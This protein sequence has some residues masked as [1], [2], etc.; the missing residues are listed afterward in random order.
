MGIAFFTAIN[1]ST[2]TANVTAFNFTDAT[3]LGHVADLSNFGGSTSTLGNA[4]VSSAIPK[5]RGKVFSVYYTTSTSINGT[6]VASIE[7]L[8]NMPNSTV[9]SDTVTNY[10]YVGIPVPGG[11]GPV[12]NTGT[13]VID[14]GGGGSGSG[15][16]VDGGS[17]GGNGSVG[18]DG[19]GVYDG[20]GI[21]AGGSGGSKVICTELYNQ[22]FLDQDIYLLDQEFGRWLAKNDP[23]AYWG[24]RAW[25]DILV[26]YMRGQGRPLLPQ[27]AFWLTQEQK[28]KLSQRIALGVAKILAKPFAYE[29]ARRVDNTNRP[30]R[31]S[32]YLVVKLGLPICK[33]IGIFK[34]S[35][36]K[37]WT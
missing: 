16:G 36:K 35:R 30:F 27:L 13:V 18:A 23:Q 29:L 31:L 5:S 33:L 25:A 4:V 34:S 20:G 10:V 6:Y 7:V 37:K 26:K 3:G 11:E 24:Y 28:Q 9:A 2:G 15:T 32:G 12:Q 8:A 22:G 19:G 1:N 21:D 14:Y 17:V